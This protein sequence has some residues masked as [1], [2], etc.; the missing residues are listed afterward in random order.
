MLRIGLLLILGLTCQVL[1]AQQFSG[2]P[3]ST[4]WKQINTD[5]VRIIFEPATEEQ[6]QRIS[7]II[8]KIAAQK[9]NAL[10]NH[11]Q[12]VNIVLH[13]NTTLANGYVALAPFRSEYY[14]IP[15]SN[16]FEL[17]NL[18]W[19]EYLAVHEYRHVQQYNNFNNG[20]TKAFNFFLGQEGRAI[21]NALTV[22]Q[23]FFEGDAVHAETALTP[24]GRGRLPLFFSG[25]NSLWEEGKNYSLLKL[26]NGSLKDYIPNHYQMGYLV[27]NYGYKKYG[28]D[29][30]EKVTADATAFKGL[31]Y[32]FNKAIRR[33]TGTPYK[34][35]MWEALNDYKQK[36]KPREIATKKR[37]TVTNYYFPQIIDN[38][39]L[40]YLK[41][42]YKKIPAFYIK[43][44][45]GERKLKLKNI[46]FEDWLSYR[47]GIIAYTAYRTNA[48]WS[49]QDYS[50]IILLDTKTGEEKRLTKRAKYFTPDISPSG[51][52]VAAVT[53]NDSLQTEIHFLN[54]SDG[55]VTG[56]IRSRQNFFLHPR[57][58]DEENIAVLKRLADGSI[59]LNRINISTTE[60]E[61][62][63]PPSF[64]V[65]GYPS[66]HNDTVY[67]T[68]AYE[69]NDDLYA[70]QL[71]DKKIFKLSSKQTGSYYPTVSGDS[72]AWS[73]FTAEGLQ[74]QTGSLKDMQWQEVTVPQKQQLLFPIAD[75]GENI[76]AI[77]N[78][79]SAISKY[80][81]ATGLFN[82]H[83][84]RP[85]YDAPEYTFTL[86]GDNILN[87]FSTEVVYRYNENERSHG[88]G[89][90]VAY[91]GLFSVLTAGAEYTY[92]RNIRI[93][94][95]QSTLPGLLN[96]YE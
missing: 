44:A 3:P 48:R 20:L 74:L 17:G 75:A 93:R 2:F 66:I 79:R 28:T 23:W 65:I 47:N 91:G 31:F 40:L 88:L 71:T 62:L 58:I 30:W 68:A 55:S 63:T 14:L 6:A 85:Y 94:T 33:Y 60:T 35:F 29:F 12:K 87:T 54:S 42:S 34:K 37:A 15:S 25:Y 27:T 90:D 69:G 24:Q 9:L 26:L 8:H 46:S 84:W 10:G 7:A 67:F 80:K 78:K 86:Y 95:P 1:F 82:F 38:N 51:N 41:D 73:Q 13:K 53:Y 57:F 32:P 72:I 56:R 61:R 21:A 39:S 49:L 96:G 22:P 70:L 4:K 92:N 43:D 81:K 83:S 52:L 19:N 36:I 77:A 89:F 18:P 50:D 45:N 59:S 16:I 11:L 64:S 76:L 5:T